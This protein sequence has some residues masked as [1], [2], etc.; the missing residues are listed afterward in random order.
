MSFWTGFLILAA[1]VAA[2]AALLLVAGGAGGRRQ[3]GAPPWWEEEEAA[4]PEAEGPWWMPEERIDHLAEPYVPCACGAH[5][6][7][8]RELRSAD[9]W[10]HGPDEC[11]NT[12]AGGLA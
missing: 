6:L 5:P 7:Q 10:L 1:W 9:G 4:G 12:R 8:G 3:K 11:C 2:G